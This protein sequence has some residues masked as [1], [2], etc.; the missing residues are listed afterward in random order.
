MSFA[1]TKCSQNYAICYDE[2]NVQ[3][4]FIS[5]IV[6]F[7]GNI[8]CIIRKI[9][10]KREFVQEVELEKELN[11][12]FLIGQITN[13]YEIIP[14]HDILNKCTI[15]DNQALGEIFISRCSALKEHS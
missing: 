14:I 9:A 11:N 4:A 8:Y 15:L 13:I 5:N 3:F 10:K 7:N 12:F 2:C 6:Q 1:N